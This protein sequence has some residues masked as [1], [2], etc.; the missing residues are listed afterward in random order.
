MTCHVD[1]VCDRPGFDDTLA[2]R[3]PRG[4]TKALGHIRTHWPCAASGDKGMQL[5]ATSRWQ[6]WLPA[7][8]SPSSA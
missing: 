3:N 6:R 5:G 2:T 7:A 8:R 1:P 4:L